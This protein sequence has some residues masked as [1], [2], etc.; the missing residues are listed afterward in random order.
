MNTQHTG[1]HQ[2][3]RCTGVDQYSDWQSHHSYPSQKHTDLNQS[4][5][6]YLHLKNE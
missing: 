6:T 1:S 2:S 5:T 4:K 3:P